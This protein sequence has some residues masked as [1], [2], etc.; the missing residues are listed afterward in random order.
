MDDQFA[1]GLV[2]H[3][4]IKDGLKSVFIRNQ[5]VIKIHM[6]NLYIREIGLSRFRQRERDRR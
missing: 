4:H 2:R 1:L 3:G 5:N 6:S